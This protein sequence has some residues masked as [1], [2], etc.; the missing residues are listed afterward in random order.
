MPSTMKSK[1][2]GVE[3]A[4]D[5][6]KDG[7]SV[8][9]SAVGMTGYPEYV[10]AKLEER[11]LER[12]SPGGLT[13]FAAGGHGGNGHACDNHFAQPGFLKRHVLT[14]PKS[15]PEL[16][17]MIANN[18][19]EGYC[20]PQ[21]VLNQ[22][23]R[24]TAARQPGLLS[25]IGIGTYVDPRQEGG[26]L[27]E[28]TKEDIVQVIELN[29]EEYL[30]YQSPKVT[31]G[32]IRGTYADESGNVTIDHEALKLEM[33]EVALAAKGCGGKVIVQV[34]HIVQNGTLNAKSVVVPGQLIDAVVVA[35]DFETWHRQAN[36]PGYDPYITGEARSP[37]GSV[38]K[39]KPVVSPNDVV[40]RRAVF[41]LFPGAIINL[42]V[43]FGS[44]AG[45]VAA[46]EGIEDQ[47]NFTLELGSFGGVPLAG[48]RFGVA[49]N[50]DSFVSPPTMFDFYHGENLDIAVLGAA[51]IDKDGNVNVSRFAGV[52]DGQG[53]FIDISTSA[54]KV[55][56]CMHM[57]AKGFEGEVTDG[58]LMIKQEGSIVKFVEK[59]E[60]ITYNGKI[61]KAA[62]HEAYFITERC[63][64]RM[65]EEG[66]TLIE[67]APGVDLQKDILDQ[68]AFAPIVSKD[69][70]LMDERIFTPGRMGCFN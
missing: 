47:L 60:Q 16:K 62:G 19:M 22:L 39:P 53:G 18:E 41:E 29:G 11:F 65:E 58:K 13:L 54:K 38:V 50:P 5:L 31:V 30:F 69:L 46:A 44:G 20:L 25:K 1:L 28:I 8:A 34:E 4:L 66:I 49:L 56:F 32:I 10:V 24:C 59:V 43:G 12:K 57:K 33:L 63:V 35:E 42:G 70:K 67:I 52:P 68:M 15:T 9:I 55:L 3:D 26:K 27:N 61:A 37:K 2:M 36:P 23:Y 14:H 21:G 48:R 6:I 17:K 64:F 7:D 45:E 40:C 51:E